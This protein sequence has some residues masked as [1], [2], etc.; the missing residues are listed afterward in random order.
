LVLNNLAAQDNTAA[1]LVSR[2]NPRLKG[3]RCSVLEASKKNLL[4]TDIFAGYSQNS[5]I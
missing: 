1:R 2:C 3:E 5:I 4:P